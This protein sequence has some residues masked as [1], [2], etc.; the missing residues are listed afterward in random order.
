MMEPTDPAGLACTCRHCAM[1]LHVFDPRLTDDALTM[2]R[3]HV[4]AAHPGV[5]LPDDA[6][7]G[8]VLAHFNVTPTP[9][10]ST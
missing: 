1:V 10:A 6:S 5:G 3:K 7:A 2:L 8:A 9:A 4:R